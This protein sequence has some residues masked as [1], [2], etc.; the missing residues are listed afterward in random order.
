MRRHLRI[1]MFNCCNVLAVK[2]VFKLWVSK[3]SKLVLVHSMFD[4]VG[5]TSD[6]NI[7]IFF[8]V[9]VLRK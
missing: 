9:G 8:I 5:D 2:V 1:L 3:V 6:F 7:I 4:K